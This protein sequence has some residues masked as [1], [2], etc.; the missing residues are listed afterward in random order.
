MDRS[1]WRRVSLLLCAA[2]AALMATAI[3]FTLLRWR[4]PVPAGAMSPDVAVIQLLGLAGFPVLA[5]LLTAHR[6]D[7][8]YAALWGA[9]GLGW[10][11]VVFAGSYVTYGLALGG[12]WPAAPVV[13]TLGDLGWC[14]AVASMPFVLLLFPDGRV[15][16]SRWRALTPVVLS[17][18]A[19]SCVAVGLMP[20]SS[21]VAPVDRWTLLGG[22]LSGIGAPLLSVSVLVLLLAVLASIVSLVVRYRAGSA[23]VRLQIRWVAFAALLVGIPF[24]TLGLANITAPGVWGALLL[25]V[26]MLA[27]CAA[28]GVA[29]LRH[30]LY[31]I[32]VIIHRTLVYGLLTVAVVIGYIAVVGS[33]SAILQGRARWPVAL[34]ATGI[35]AVAFH[36]LRERLQRAVNRLLYGDRDEPHEVVS[37]LADR[38]ATTPEPAAVLPTVVDTVAQALRLPHVSI[39]QVDGDVLRLAAG[40]FAPSPGIEV[41]DAVAED[42]FRRATRP[43][44]LPELRSAGTFGTALDTAGVTLAFP[45]RHAGELVGVLCAAPRRAGESWSDPDRRALAQLARHTG[46][47][48]HADRLT[49]ALRRSLEELRRSQQRLVTTQEQERRRIQGDLHDGLGPTLAAI[50]LHLETCL[51]PG[52]PVPAWLRHELGRIDELVGEAGSDVRRLVYGLRPPTLDQLGLV[53]ALNQHVLQFGR[54]TGVAARFTGAAVG[55]PSAAVQITIFRVAQEAL[56]NVVK[57]AHATSVDVAMWNEDARLHLRVDDDGAGFKQGAGD[58]TGL[59]GMRDRAASVGGAVTLDSRPGGGT[60]LSLTVPTNPEP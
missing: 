22:R 59:R 21:S 30:R 32:D 55:S 60:R 25:T 7:P 58:G 51:D 47:V 2:A 11:A 28:V 3:A 56:T 38:L 41:A 13:G 31:D 46:A 10:G 52:T 18:G 54:D 40:R 14:I 49:T 23:L 43:L 45:L 34:V 35:V 26:P 33:L 20:G 24:A 53:A 9:A 1:F 37:R 6:A 39:W 48:V 12:A 19:G 5:L 29:V 57:H 27:M 15:P 36:P 16:S 44:E 17:A 50:R 8:F 4:L 42:L